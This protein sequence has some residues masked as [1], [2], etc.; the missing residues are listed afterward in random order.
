MFKRIHGDEVGQIM[1]ARKGWDGAPILRP[2]VVQTPAGL[3]LASQLVKA[4]G[5]LLRLLAHHP[6]AVAMATAALLVWLRLG[7]LALAGCVS[8]AVLGLGC[9]WYGHRSSFSRLVAMPVLAR[10]RWVTVYRSHWDAAMT[11]SGLAVSWRERDYLP[12]VVRLRCTARVDRLL[13]EMVTGQDIDAWEKT[14]G[15]LAHTFG[16]TACR[17]RAGKPRH[18]RVEF[19]RG[20]PL[21]EPIDALPI[22][23]AVNLSAVPVGYCADGTPW[24]VSLLGASILIGGAQGAGKGSVLWSLIRGVAPAV[25]AGLVQV[26]AVDP[27]GG[28]ELTFGAGLFARFEHRYWEPE[29]IADLLEEAVTLLQQRTERLRGKT[30]QHAPTTDEP[31]VLVVVDEL[32]ALTAYLQ[33]KSA[34]TR[35]KNALALIASQG[36]AVGVVPIGALQDP[37]KEVLSFRDLFTTRIALRLVEDD[38]VDMVLGDGARDRG[39]QCDRIP[40]SLPGVGYVLLDGDREPTRVRAAYVTDTQITDMATTYPAPKLAPATA[41]L[42][43]V[44]GDE[45]SDRR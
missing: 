45:G 30:R 21:S 40:K 25:R 20:D 1:Q 12:Q 10:W 28:M 32:A 34:R 4:L 24:T 11:L 31:L 15:A 5:R 29:R 36:R 19:T 38:Q 9:W 39:A 41:P 27:K 13:V 35:I 42:R 43:L 7:A 23:D 37:R 3:M 16:A 8:A 26:W 44:S 2:P 14:A 18:V 22:P 17:I 33:D 6:V